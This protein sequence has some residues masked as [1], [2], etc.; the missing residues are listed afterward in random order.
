MRWLGTALVLLTG[1]ALYLRTSGVRQR[2]N[3][4]AAP[5]SSFMPPALVAARRTTASTTRLPPRALALA[6]LTESA[7]TTFIALDAEGQTD[8]FA[9]PFVVDGRTITLAVSQRDAS[10]SKVEKLHAGVLAYLI[11]PGLDP[12]Q[13]Y[14]EVHELTRRSGWRIQAEEGNAIFGFALEAQGTRLVYLEADARAVGTRV[15]WWVVAV[16]LANG[17]KS[18]MLDGAQ[19]GAV[20]LLPLDWSA[21][22]ILFRGLTPFTNQYHGL[23]ATDSDGSDLRPVIAETDYVGRPRLS[24]EGD[25][26]AL[27]VSDPSALPIARRNASAGEPPANTIRILDLRQG[28]LTGV[29]PS[30]PERDLASLDWTPDGLMVIAGGWGA[31]RNAFDHRSVVLWPSPPAPLPSGSAPLGKGETQLS[32]L[33]STNRGEITRLAACPD[34]G[35]LAAVQFDDKTQIIRAGRA[36]PLAE[37]VGPVIDWLACLASEAA[38]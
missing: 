36:A 6:A 34:G 29:S 4:L 31:D 26:L 1:V 7:Q 27:L 8:A 33:Y 2:D 14:I 12:T 35:W 28:E 11:L 21:D 37:F 38:P 16:D 20:G 23:W 32:I 25:R 30:A 5:G 13:N 18:V 3:P 19:A 22:T 9:G 17:V 10:R 24:P 15:P